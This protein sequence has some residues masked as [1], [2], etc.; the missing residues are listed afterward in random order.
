MGRHLT[1]SCPHSRQHGAAVRLTACARPQ[2][3]SECVVPVT[4]VP[5]TAPGGGVPTMRCAWRSSTCERCSAS[6]RC[7][8]LRKTVRA[9][10]AKV[11]T[12]ACGETA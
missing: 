6:E 10:C 11:R 7:R 3:Q 2:P 4:V 12:A 8:G 9:W 1:T 5:V